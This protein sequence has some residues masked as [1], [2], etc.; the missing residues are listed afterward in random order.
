MIGREKFGYSFSDDNLYHNS[1]YLLTKTDDTKLENI[2]RLKELLVQIDVTPVEIELE[3]HDFYVAVISHIPHIIA[4]D[5]VNLVKCT[6][7]EKMTMK[8]IAAGGLKDITRIAFANPDMW[9]NICIQN[10]EENLLVCSF[11]R[12]LMNLKRTLIVKKKL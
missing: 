4:S 6:D 10:K 8:T 7:D 3:K 9:K 2:E 12:L 5:L 11:K 1:Y